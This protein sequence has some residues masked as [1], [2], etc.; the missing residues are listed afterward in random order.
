MKNK[1]LVSY[2]THTITLTDQGREQVG[3]EALEV[4]QNNDAMQKKLKED[5]KSKRSREIFDLLIDGKAY[6]RGEL[7]DMLKM[8]NNKSFGT[9]VS[10]LSKLTERI[11]GGKIRLKDIAFPVGRPCD[12]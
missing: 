12:K 8:E 3:P 9:Y 11:D 7:A 10:S 6:S 2:D 1:G 5:I 4:P